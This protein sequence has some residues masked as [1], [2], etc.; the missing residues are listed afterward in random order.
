MNNEMTT[1]N[2][3]NEEVTEVLKGIVFNGFDRTTSKERQAL[4]QAIKV[5]EQRPQGDLISRSDLYRKIKTE[6]NPYGK[7]T[8]DFES[9]NR[10]LDLIDN[11][12]TVERPQGKWVFEEY[13][14]FLP[15]DAEP[16]YNNDTYDEK[17]HSVIDIHIVC[18]ECGAE[19]HFYHKFCGNCGADMQPEDTNGSRG[20]T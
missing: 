20:E 3:S 9:G 7:P 4:D 19:K 15:R 14:K 13:R 1:D 17:T 10:V 6:C 11:A 8:I 18:S 16:D 5:L 2:M 12:P